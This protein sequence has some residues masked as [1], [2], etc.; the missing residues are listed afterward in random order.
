MFFGNKF[1]VPILLQV[2]PTLFIQKKG[3]IF[4]ILFDAKPKNLVA[5]TLLH[6]IVLPCSSVSKSVIVL[7]LF[8]F[9]FWTVGHR[10]ALEYNAKQQLSS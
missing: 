1:H 2:P 8:L 5:Y 4:I 3:F 6:Y 9:G 7:L 10:D